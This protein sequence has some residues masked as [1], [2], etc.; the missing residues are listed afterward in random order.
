MQSVLEN[1]LPQLEKTKEAA[2]LRLLF[3]CTGNT[4]RSP[5]AAALA[6]ALAKEKGL[7]LEASSAGLAANEGD[8]ISKNAVLALDALALPDR[9]YRTHLAHTVTEDDAARFDLLVGV[10][11]RHALGLLYA[12]PDL[13]AKITCLPADIPDPYGG[14]LAAYESCLA[15]LREAISALLFPEVTP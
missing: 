12:F 8:P 1:T 10:T 4:C 15:A 7:P 6:N 14:D 9:S 11:K 2:P 5:M 3:V 13:A